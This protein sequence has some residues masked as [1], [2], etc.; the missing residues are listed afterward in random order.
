MRY[1]EFWQLVDE[2]LGSG[3]GRALVRE[4]VLDRLGNRT[5]EQALDAGVEPR[6]VWHALCDALDIPDPQRWGHDQHRQAPP[7]R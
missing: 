2:V 5:A 7:R 4:L 1:R 6:D 3:H